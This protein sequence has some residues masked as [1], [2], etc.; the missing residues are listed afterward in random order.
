MGLARLG[1]GIGG[2]EASMHLTTTGQ[3]MGTVEYMSPEQAEDT[4]LADARS[5]IY[6]LGCTLYRLV[7]G[8]AP[9]ARDTVVKTIIAHREAAIPGL[10]SERHPSLAHLESLF[11]SMVAKNPADR[12]QNTTLLIRELQRLSDQVEFSD[13]NIIVAD[14]IEV[15]GR[16]GSGPADFPTLARDS[17]PT[18]KY[19]DAFDVQPRDSH[20][21]QSPARSEPYAAPPEALSGSKTTN[22]FSTPI[23]SKVA[24]RE[25]HR[26][27]TILTMGVL[28]LVFAFPCFIGVVLGIVTWVYAH[29]DLS[30][31]QQGWRDPAG[32]NLTQAG[33]ILSII[34]CSIGAIWTIV[35]IFGRL[36]Q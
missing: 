15:V 32:R 26:G 35:V 3:V 11:K 9:Y 4:R 25:K 36:N 6:S 29:N 7:T 33:H 17:G 18:P 24:G 30:E 31:M 13:P 23:H 34:S 8:K 27:R 16:S 2:A 28:S 5:N 14:E 20:Q 19:S 10:A 22:K 1:K 21:T 12:I